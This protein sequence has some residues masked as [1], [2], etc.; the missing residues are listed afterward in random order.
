VEWRFRLT[1]STNHV[2]NYE[3]DAL[4]IPEPD[5]SLVARV[6]DLVPHLLS[7]P[8][9]TIVDRELDELW[10]DAYR[11]NAAARARITAAV[12]G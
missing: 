8:D 4:P 6:C 11:L 2:G 1:S 9:N 7:Q 3:L 10:F 5:A 12:H